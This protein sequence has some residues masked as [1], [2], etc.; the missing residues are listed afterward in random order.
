MKNKF[1]PPSI[2]TIN[3]LL[4]AYLGVGLLL[5]AIIIILNAYR[6][7]FEYV[8]RNPESHFG[9]PIYAGLL[10]KIRVILWSASMSICFFS[11]L[12]IKVYSNSSRVAKFIF[13]SAILTFL[14]FIDD[15]F[16]IHSAFRLI[17]HIQNTF[18]YLAYAIYVLYV[19]YRFKEII[20]SS[21][22]KILIL[23]CILLGLAVILDLLSDTKLITSGKEEVFEASFKLFG[24][25]T[26]TIYF[27]KYCFDNLKVLVLKH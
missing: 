9:I 26:W 1:N 12:V 17:L 20:M 2:S 14:L 4:L 13:Y 24:V 3:I 8:S 16:Q 18:V 22:Y 11:Y 21:E 6:I 25:V 15:Y 19:I 27:V 10:Q 23:A 5:F 7:P